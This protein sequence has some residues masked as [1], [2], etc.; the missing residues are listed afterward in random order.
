M[1]RP[2]SK[3]S[4]KRQAA[5][6]CSESRPPLFRKLKPGPGRPTAQ[7]LANQRARLH[8]AMVELV[9]DRGVDRVT[10][11]GLSRLAG[12][13]TRTFY[14]HFA[15]AQECL[16]SSVD[17]VA[18][19][20][21]RRAANRRGPW[22]DWEEGVRMTLR[23]LM[24]D[25]AAE[26]K[27]TGLLLVEVF[28]GGAG[29]RSRAEL[30]TEDLE[31]LLAE[32][33]AAAPSGGELSNRLVVGTAAGIT[34]VATTTLLTERADELPALAEPLGDWALSLHA[35]RMVGPP[36][37]LRSGPALGLGHE[38]TRLPRRK[39]AR[40]SRSVRQGELE[41]ML[42]AVAKL[43]GAEG[44]ASLTVPTIRQEAGVSRRSFDA[45]F[46]NATECFLAAIE[47]LA[48]SAAAKA[49]GWAAG[50][51]GWE[52]RVQRT[53]L[54]LCAQAARNQRLAHLAFIEVLAPG[55]EGLLRRERMITQGA[56]QLR[57]LTVCDLLPGDLAAE[58]SA[59]AAWRIAQA[60]IAAGAARQLPLIAPLLA[61]VVLSPVIGASAAI[62][63]LRIERLEG[64]L[65]RGKTGARR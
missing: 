19:R 65:K 2:T 49:A 28:A 48:H 53:M 43:A 42:A 30:F 13:S 14:G 6:Q 47:A 37:P 1:S 4:L 51:G 40:P 35:G 11:R 29:A 23:S 54:A 7:V 12:V 8:G 58:A 22:N 24:A 57:R 38:A 46:D 63:T 25:L 56:A 61:Y 18:R 55:R 3:T 5:P 36:D 17:S 52:Q 27:A 20:F 9:A 32:R 64:G 60:D 10:V 21:L 16:A 31:R 15:N 59:A 33:L 44:F 45:C 39:G 41:R 26:P 34:R 50:A 62:E